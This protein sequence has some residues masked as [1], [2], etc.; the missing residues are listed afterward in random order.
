MSLAQFLLIVAL[1]LFA[2]EF[3][4]TL[5]EIPHGRLHLIAAGLALWVTTVAFPHL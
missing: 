4:L 5:L 3:V 1:F 2:T